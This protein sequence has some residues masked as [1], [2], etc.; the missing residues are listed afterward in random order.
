MKLGLRKDRTS[1]DSSQVR[2]SRVLE[3]VD[4]EYNTGNPW[5]KEVGIF[6]AW[7]GGFAGAAG[8]VVAVLLLIADLFSAER[9]FTGR[10]LSDWTFWSATILMLIGLIAPAS[11]DV[12]KSTGKNKQREEQGEDRMTRTVRKRLRRVY[13]PWRWRLW[14][15]ALLA[16]GLSILFGILA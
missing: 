10:S 1:D 7:A 11:T 13:D 8:V 5:W 9:L 16:F 14:G 15:S 2:W 12:N 3:E 6:F 4:E